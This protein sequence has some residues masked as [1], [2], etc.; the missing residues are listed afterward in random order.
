MAA[1]Q[2]LLESA[3]SDVATLRFYGWSQPTLSLG[4][5]QPANSRLGDKRLASLPF[6][7]RPTGGQ[8]LVHDHE[9]TYALAFPCRPPWQPEAEKPSA[10][11]GR[12]H[13]VVADALRTLGV[14]TDVAGGSPIPMRANLQETLESRL[15]PA[16]AGTPAMQPNYARSSSGKPETLCFLQPVT[17]DLLIGPHKIA[18]SAQRRHR[19]ALLQHG[20][21]LLSASA[22]APILLGVEEL[23]GT[24]L[25]P[26]ELCDAIARQFSERFSCRLIPV[27][28][29]ESEGLKIAAL[30]KAQYANEAWNLKR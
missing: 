6:V 27:E 5:F 15:Q 19:G 12:M 11:L 21:V 24:R 17:G 26:S 9:I 2:V 29:S 10:W 13:T 20:A 28:W 16:K 1:D 7:R 30:V 14:E 3:A 8:T 18:G 4:Y 23:T 25:R 22:H